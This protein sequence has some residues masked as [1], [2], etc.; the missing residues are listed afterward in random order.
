MPVRLLWLAYPLS[1]GG[2]LSR[3]LARCYQGLGANGQTAPG[4]IPSLLARRSWP[5][6]SLVS[7]LDQMY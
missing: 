6:A 4:L 2:D 3:Y 1:L 7:F 5:Q